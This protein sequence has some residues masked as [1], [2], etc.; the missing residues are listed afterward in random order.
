MSSKEQAKQIIRILKEQNPHPATELNFQTPWQLLVA[1]ILAAQSTDKQVNK[2]TAKLFLDYPQ[3]SDLAALTENQLAE[4]I[5]TLGLFRNKSKHLVATARKIVKKYSGEVP[6]TLAELQGLPGVGRKTA[7]V[8]LANA[9]GIPAFAV[10]THVFRVANRTGL[11]TA[12]T[13]E[14]TEKQLTNLIPRE[15]WRDAHHWLILHGRYICTARK[16]QCPRCPI[17]KYCQTDKLNT[18]N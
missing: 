18:T 14:Q 13:P 3:P 1:T 11:A 2:V 4:S 16:P 10:D 17:A 12:K 9:F 15:Q 8:V 5:K 7:N 6:R